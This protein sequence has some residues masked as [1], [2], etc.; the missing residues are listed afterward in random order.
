MYKVYQCSDVLC[1]NCWQWGNNFL[2][3]VLKR[4]NDKFL[5]FKKK[6]KALTGFTNLI[7]LFIDIMLDVGVG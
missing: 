7:A 5:K 6:K 3:Q 4:I 1:Q 2:K